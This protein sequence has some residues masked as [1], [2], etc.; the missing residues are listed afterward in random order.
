MR[1]LLAVLALC[2]T[3]LPCL[4]QLALRKGELMEGMACKADETQTYT[5]YLPTSFDSG[6]AWPVL[7]IYDPRGRSKLAAEIFRPAAEQYG[8]IL[9]SSNDTRSDGPPEP[10]IKALNALIPELS[11]YPVDGKRVYMTGFSGGAMLAFL[12]A[13]QSDGGVAGV[14]GCGGRFP[15]GWQ[16]RPVKFAHWGV[17]GTTDFNYSPMREIDE[18]LETVGAA[19]RF[20][21]F[22]GAH[23]WMPEELATDAVEWMELD[24][25]R[26]GLRERDAAMIE[27]LWKE[28]LDGAA[29]VEASGDL[30]QVLRRWKAI[31]STFRDLR[32]VAIARARVE[33]L[34]KDKAVKAALREQRK[35]DEWEARMRRQMGIAVATLRNEERP[36]PVGRLTGEL[37]LGEINRHAAAGGYEALAAG[38]VLSS[39]FSQLSFYL[40]REFMTAQRYDRAALVLEVADSMR[41]GVPFVLYNLACSRSRLGQKDAALDA[42]ERAVAA[43][44]TDAVQMRTDE[45]LAAVRGEARF[46]E[47]LAKM[48]K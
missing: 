37:R 39:M 6:R 38:R 25:M 24:A 27:R 41:P 18:F 44:F 31:E 10:N 35:W 9:I 3:T 34:E 47:L 45:D 20:E 14:I 46:G 21:S 28:D 2:L 32:D 5:L 40:P 11:R 30:A 1:S 4:A 43:G 13:A 8:W 16:Q 23:Q 33:E 48:Q 19:H 26:R 29:A 12:V 36:V 42:L 15:E 17:A 7:L 22:E